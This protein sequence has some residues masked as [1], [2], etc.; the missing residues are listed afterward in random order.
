MELSVQLAMG[1]VLL[2]ARHADPKNLT[3][4]INMN[5]AG[6]SAWRI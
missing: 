6:M 5:V 1:L 3:M 4:I 2:S